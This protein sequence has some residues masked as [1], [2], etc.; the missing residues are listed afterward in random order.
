M[1]YR[2]FLNKVVYGSMR[3][4]PWNIENMKINPIYKHYNKNVGKWSFKNVWNWWYWIAIFVKFFNK[5]SVSGNLLLV[6]VANN[7]D[8]EDSESNI[9]LE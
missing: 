9:T 3:A 1:L 2:F 6:D 7:K 5:I 4:P 8:L